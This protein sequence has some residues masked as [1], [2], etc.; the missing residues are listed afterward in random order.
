MMSKP[1]KSEEEEGRSSWYPFVNWI[2]GP[3]EPVW[4]LGV[5]VKIK[6]H[7]LCQKSSFFLSH[8]QLLAELFLFL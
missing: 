8:S 1:K 2:I 5:V 3:P 4:V 7:S 6:N